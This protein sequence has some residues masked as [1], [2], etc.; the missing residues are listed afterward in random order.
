MKCLYLVLFLTSVLYSQ[1]ALT[2]VVYGDYDGTNFSPHTIYEYEYNS[3]GLV[4]SEKGFDPVN[5]NEIFYVSNYTYNENDRLI[6]QEITDYDEGEITSTESD[7]FS[8]NS[9]NQLIRLESNYSDLWFP[10][11][12]YHDKL[13]FT[14]ENGV[15]VEAI[16][17]VWNGTDWEI[18]S[19]TVFEFEGPNL[20]T[21]FNYDWVSNNWELMGK[22]DYTYD[23]NGNLLT[24]SIYDWLGAGYELWDYYEYTY[25][26]ANNVISEENIEEGEVFY[27][28][29]YTYNTNDLMENYLN[30][31]EE[32]TG[33]DRFFFGVRK[34]HNKLI[35]GIT[36]FSDFQDKHIYNYGNLSVEN[37]EGK[38]NKLVLY[39]NPAAEILT[40]KGLKEPKKYTI[41]NTKGQV[42]AKGMT[43]EN[44]SIN[45]RR[46]NNGVYFIQLENEKALKF[47]KK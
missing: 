38:S 22:T 36:D 43:S 44:Q 32:K 5:N 19:K 16:Y 24:E 1:P 42:V 21:T 4:S 34:H 15:Y 23:S 20:S 41:I 46:L 27:R 11:F 9:N 25:D 17:N 33:W 6:S 7:Q 8:Y 45:V 13:D 29:E 30:P 14:I 2:S 12:S 47:I 26:S 39:P 37:A 40:I 31:F 35:E 3:N 10:E 28:D 18:N